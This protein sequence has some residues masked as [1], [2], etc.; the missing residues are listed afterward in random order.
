[1]RLGRMLARVLTHTA[2]GEQP[3][4]PVERCQFS[5]HCMCI[6]VGMSTTEGVMSMKQAQQEQDVSLLALDQYLREVKQLPRLS[7][8]E[9]TRCF[10]RV[11]RAKEEPENQRLAMLA[12]EAR[13]RLVERYQPLVISIARR[14]L[15][16]F[17]GLTLEDLIQEGNCGLIWAIDHYQREGL[18]LAYAARAIRGAILR[19][20]RNQDGLIR[21]PNH[22]HNA[23]AQ[24]RRTAIALRKRLGREPSLAEVAAQMGKEE[25]EVRSLDEVKQVRSVLS[26]EGLLVEDEREEDQR[27]FVSLFAASVKQEEARQAELA[28]LLQ[29]AMASTLQ[30]SER[31]A[32]RL[33][34]GI[35]DGADAGPVDE[36]ERGPWHTHRLSYVGHRAEAQLREALCYEIV[37]GQPH[38]R[39]LPA[40][41]QAC[42][43]LPQV[44]QLLDLNER[45]VGKYARLGRLPALRRPNALAMVFPKAAIDALVDRTPGAG[46]SR[47]VLHARAGGAAARHFLDDAAALRAEWAG[48]RVA[49]WPAVAGVP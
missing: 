2:S 3:V 10:Q 49:A 9:E 42:Y 43:T 45:T 48:S 37:N 20:F 14:C 30:S 21:L 40:F 27:Q 36:Y 39:L 41:E 24:K 35:D 19:S 16:F 4:L 22:V 44:A 5:V 46:L 8:E 38:Y 31:S 13:D 15:F 1:M 12:R 47:G 6:E 11:A 33:R 26:L 23:L 32:L 7:Q 28:A 25:H 34:H 18:F 29:Q 17:E